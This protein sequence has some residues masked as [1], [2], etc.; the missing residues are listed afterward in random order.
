VTGGAIV[1]EIKQITENDDLEMIVEEISA[2]KWSE[3]SEIGSSDY[4]VETLSTFIQNSYS[5]FLIAYLEER[6]SGMASAMVLDKP[7]G[8]SWLFIDEIDV[9]EDFHRKGVATQMMK[10]LFLLASEYECDE[11]WLGAEKENVAA[12]ELYRNLNPIEIQEF[13]GYTYK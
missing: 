1:I 9:C 7:N 12:N 4:T 2:A 13:L 8:D 11:I 5:I 3:D 6:F 10:Q